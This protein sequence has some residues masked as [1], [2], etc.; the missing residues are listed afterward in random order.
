MSSQIDCDSVDSAANPGCFSAIR[1][2]LSWCWASKRPQARA[3]LGVGT[4]GDAQL[5]PH[6]R[7]GSVDHVA[8]SS[9]RGVR[10][11]V[12]RGFA[13]RRDLALVQLGEG[14]HQ[15]VLASGKV[16]EQASLGNSGASADLANRRPAVADLDDRRDRGVEQPGNRR[17][18]SL[19]LRAPIGFAVIHRESRLPGRGSVARP[20][21]VPP[22]RW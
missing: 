17:G 10:V 19:V 1:R 11:G 8:H 15:E 2:S 22:I 14:R 5:Q 3:Q 21:A 20:P 12:R 16:A 6:G 4:S 18:G 7:V 9:D 13:H